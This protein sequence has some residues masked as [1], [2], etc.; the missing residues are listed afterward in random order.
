MLLFNIRDFDDFQYLFGIEIHGNGAKSRRNKIMLAHV[1]NRQLYKYCR[2]HDDY[3]L[4]RV[5]SMPELKKAVLNQVHISGKNDDTLQHEV[6]LM[7]MTFFSSLYRTDD[8][9]GLCFDLDGSSVRY[10]NVERNREYKKKSGKFIVGI[11]KETEVG[12]LLNEQ[13]INWISEEFTYDWETYT[14]YNHP[15]IKLNVDDNFKA[16]YDSERCKNFYG[17]SCMENRGRH[18][19]Y[20]DRVKSKAAYLTDANDNILARAIIFTDVK[21]QNGKKWRLLER[22]YASE[23]SEMLKR[24]LIERCVK[25]GYVDGYKVCGAACQDA[26]NFVDVQGRSLADYEF[27][28]ECSVQMDSCLSYM[29]SFK[30]LD[31]DNE[32]AYNFHPGSGNI[33]QLDTTDYNLNGDSD[34]D[35]PDEDEGVYD[36]WHEEYVDEVQRVYYQ[37]TLYYCDIER[38]DDFIYVPS[39]RQWHHEEDIIRCDNCGEAILKSNA[40]HELK[41]DSVYCSEDCR[42]EHIEQTWYYSQWDDERF[43]YVTD[44]TTCSQWDSETQSYHRLSISVQSLEHLKCEG[45]AFGFGESWFIMAP[46]LDAEAA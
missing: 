14:K 35:D 39:Q 33:Y 46:S 45:K 27:R 3:S 19:F 24:L 20:R 32:V 40:I 42:T 5:R 8:N 36:E 13:V 21:D 11:I 23:S 30:W 25:E 9:K 1:K 7:G 37:G 4:L 44:I 26:R 34:D 15:E 18:T 17:C 16:I 43:P 22:Q 38:L 28:I 31:Y 12:K 29:D 10:I 6:S 2:E 41:D